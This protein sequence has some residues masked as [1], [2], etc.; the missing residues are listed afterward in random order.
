[1][2]KLNSKTLVRIGIVLGV[3]LIIILLL[4]SK[5]DKENILIGNDKDKVNVIETTEAAVDLSGGESYKFVSSYTSP[6]EEDINKIYERYGM[7]NVSITDQ[8]IKISA[9]DYDPSQEERLITNIWPDTSLTNNILKPE[10]GEIEEIE[11]GKTYIKIRLIN[12]NKKDIEKYAKEI[13]EDFSKT[14]N[15]NEINSIYEGNNESGDKV[16]IMFESKKNAGY[17]TYNY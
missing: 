8:G 1:M 10:F 3:L 7:E 16:K 14:T 17:I 4:L 12:V 9:V 13:K 6:T 2:E 15:N 11:V 5:K